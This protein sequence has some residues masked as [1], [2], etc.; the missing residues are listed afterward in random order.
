MRKKEPEINL[1]LGCSLEAMRE[2]K[3]N[4]YDLAIVDPP[5]GIKRSGQKLSIC[6]N[7]NHNRKYFEDKGWDNEIPPPEYFEHLFRVSK[8]QIIWGG[9]Y[10]AKYLYPSKGWIVW[11]K[12]QHGLSMSDCEL[13]FSSFKRA[14]RIWTK[15]RSIFVCEG[16]TI[17]PTQKPIA[18]Y[19]W[20]LENYSKE[21]DKILDTHLGSGS[22]ACACY[23]LG[24]DLD[25]WEIDKDYY[26]DTLLRYTEYS[27]QSKLF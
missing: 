3:D 7:P 6:K 1:H 8:E 5:Y 10:F 21:G 17:H 2:M 20:L 15:N 16:G 4:Q 18:L 9:N 11:D 13:A 22:I 19:K 14:T 27:K 24:F 12:A 23:D 26:K 25:A